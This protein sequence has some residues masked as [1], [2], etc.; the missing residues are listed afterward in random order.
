MPILGPIR[1][2]YYIAYDTAAPNPTPETTAALNEIVSCPFTGRLW[3]QRSPVAPSIWSQVLP[4]V[5]AD[6]INPTKGVRMRNIN[7]DMTLARPQ[8]MTEGAFDMFGV[9]TVDPN[10]FTFPNEEVG[11]VFLEAGKKLRSRALSEWKIAAD[12]ALTANTLTPLTGSS[13][14]AI[15]AG[16][17]RVVFGATFQH[18]NSFDAS[19]GIRYWSSASTNSIVRSASCH[20][21]SQ[22]YA[23]AYCEA[24]V[25]LQAD[26]SV[27]FV[28]Q[29]SDTGVTLKLLNPV[30]FPFAGYATNQDSCTYR[31]VER[32]S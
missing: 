19:I 17:Y 24:I 30:A 4:W 28:V 15:E 18:N 1:P 23:T 13:F 6:G 5:Q 2:K 8:G 9:A 12:L 10:G 21:Q 26:E 32:I 3:L 27:R 7:G 22:G 14:T 20:A 11:P 31:V 29:A 16:T 25:P